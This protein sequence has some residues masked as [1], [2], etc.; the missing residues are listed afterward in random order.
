ME[1]SLF[2]LQAGKKAAI[3]RLGNGLGFQKKLASLNI[4]IGKTIR[5]V[6]SQPFGG[7]VVIKIDNTEVTL[8]MKVARRIFVEESKT[9]R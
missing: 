1:I 7:P 6:A 4:R 3:K 9:S 2:D 5:K 8:G